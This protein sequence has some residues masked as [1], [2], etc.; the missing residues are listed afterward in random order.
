MPILRGIAASNIGNGASTLFWKNSWLTR[1]ATDS[2]PRA[3]S[4]VLDEAISVQ[5]FLSSNSLAD[6]FHLPDF[7]KQWQSL[8]NC[9]Q[10]LL[11]LTFPRKMTLE[12]MPRAPPPNTLLVS[13]TN[14]VLGTLCP[15]RFLLTLEMQINI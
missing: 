5:D 3:Y 8:E 9:K 13:S 6:L 4:F 2:Y 11:V 15:W 12:L 10:T 7:L 14:F 1:S